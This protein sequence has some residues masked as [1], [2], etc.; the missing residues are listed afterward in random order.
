MNYSL[1]D[2][3]NSGKYPVVYFDISL[4]EENMGKLVI[5]LFRDIFP[6][7]VENFVRISSGKTYRIEKKGVGAYNYYKEVK[8]TY[9]DC[10]FYKHIYNSYIVSGDIYN[11]NGT[12]AGTIYNDEPIPPCFGDYY[13]QHDRKGLISL[14]PYYDEEKNIYFYDSTFLITLDDVKPWNLLSSLDE[15]HVV[16]GEVYQGLDLIDKMNQ[17]LIP[18]SGRRYPIFD[19]AKSDVYKQMN[20]SRMIRTYQN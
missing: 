17:L 11:N 19:I 14:V 1:C 5:K 6:A 10:S 9:S 3:P 20:Y 2:L 13:Y 18:Y 12:S 4:K 7:G 16:I 15:N 8:R